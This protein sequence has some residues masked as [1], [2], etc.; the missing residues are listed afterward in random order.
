MPEKTDISPILEGWA[1]DP[2]VDLIVRK[3]L[4]DDGLEKVQMR[5]DMGLLQMELDGRPDGEHPQGHE[6]HLAY[7]E[8]HLTQKRKTHGTEQGFS[9]SSEMCDELRGEAIQYYYRY[10]SLLK[11]GDYERVTRD[12]AR[13]LRVLDLMKTYAADEDD[14]EAFQ[15][16]RPYI[17]M[18]N[19]RAR[20]SL[21]LEHDDAEEALGE[22]EEGMSKIRDFYRESGEPEKIAH[23][24]E[25]GVLRAMGD[26]IRRQGVSSTER[27]LRQKLEAA[28]EAEDFEG[29]AKLRDILR[30]YRD[31]DGSV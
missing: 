11:L 14:R 4:G 5:L 9:L 2:E 29:A 23:S 6:S 30:T 19:T 31:A 26:G 28:I 15:E 17:L 18:M 16:F 21:S 7:Y 20:A 8:S 1:F 27:R 3:I 13:N 10:L 12:T 22:I 25:L 24:L